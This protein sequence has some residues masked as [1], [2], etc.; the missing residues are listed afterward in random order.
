MNTFRET[1]FFEDE[2][3]SVEKVLVAKYEYF[4]KAPC[5]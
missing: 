4:T 2:P 3:D 5:S 1:Q